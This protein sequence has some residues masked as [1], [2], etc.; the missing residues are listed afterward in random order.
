[1]KRIQWS[2]M[3]LAFVLVASAANA[4]NAKKKA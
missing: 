3:G 2:V 1:M 4:A